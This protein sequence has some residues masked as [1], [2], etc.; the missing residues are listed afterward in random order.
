MST[1]NQTMKEGPNEML[2]DKEKNIKLMVQ[3][4]TWNAVQLKLEGLK[5]ELMNDLKGIDEA[6]AYKYKRKI[7]GIIGNTSGW[8]EF[9]YYFKR[10]HPDFFDRLL[11]EFPSLSQ[12]DLRIC[13]F[14]KL[15]LS[16]KDIASAQNITKRGVEQAKRRL[17]VKLKLSSTKEIDEF[18]MQF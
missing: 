15:R 17:K 8:L 12:N 10:V 13:A 16:N 1:G 14:T 9:E 2:E 6:K 11:E 5:T 7:E 4:M 3:A 18:L